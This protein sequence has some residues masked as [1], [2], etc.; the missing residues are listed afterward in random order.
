MEFPAQ[1][2]QGGRFAQSVQEVTHAQ[3]LGDVCGSGRSRKIQLNVELK[4]K[5]EVEV[6]VQVE[7]EAEVGLKNRGAYSLQIR[8][9]LETQRSLPMPLSAAP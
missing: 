6:E 8:P 2:A 4:S 3:R 5:G 9:Q 7:A 1:V